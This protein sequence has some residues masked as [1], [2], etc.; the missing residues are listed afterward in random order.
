MNKEQLEKLLPL[1]QIIAVRVNDGLHE[2]M[3]KCMEDLLARP[4][5]LDEGEGSTEESG[6]YL[7]SVKASATMVFSGLLRQ[8]REAGC[9]EDVRSAILEKAEALEKKLAES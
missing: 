4:E 5:L 3:N 2:L 7:A 1:S 8:L 6:R 9:P